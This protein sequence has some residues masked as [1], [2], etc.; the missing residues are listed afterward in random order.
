MKSILLNGHGIDIRVSQAKLKIKDGRYDDEIE[1][2]T[3][4]FS[5]KRI[6]VNNVIIYGRSGGISI[7][8][9]KWLIKHN[10]QVTILDWNGKLLTTMLPPEG[11]Q[12]KTKFSQ[13][14][15]YNDPEIKLELAKK[16]IFAKIKRTQSV[17]DYLKQRYELEYDFKKELTNLDNSKDVSEIMLIEA[18]VAGI[19]WKILKR[20]FPEKY[21]FNTRKY[22][23]RPGGAGDQINCMLNYGYSLLEA[24][25]LRAIN[26]AGLDAHIGFLHEMKIG[27][28]SLAYDL[29]EPFRFLIDL[30]VISA[31]EKGLMEKRDF[32]RTENYNLRLRPS[33]AKKLLAEVLYQ[34]NKKV[35]YRDREYSWSYVVMT[36]TIELAHYLLGK[37][38][39]FNLSLPI[40]D[41]S[42]DD[43]KEL[44]EKILNIS[45]YR[46]QKAGFSKG[47]LSYL[48]KNARSDKPFKVNKHVLDRLENME[49]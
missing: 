2:E 43:T 12:V 19:Y 26:S 39:S 47:A 21:E 46:W 5:P 38:E 1:P 27:K 14:A 3:F 15:S 31:I 44:R 9:I 48:K 36:Q 25:C 13:Y 33:G 40:P 41:L 30:A 34:F 23:G 37:K 45:I 10:V 4:V 6:D 8:A 29:Q 17:L 22:T 7:E 16:F 28:N 35:Y 20:I 18:R 11:V 32:I 49:I 24:E 42:R